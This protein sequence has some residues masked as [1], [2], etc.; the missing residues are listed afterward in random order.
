LTALGVPGFDDF[1]YQLIGRL[2]EASNVPI[3]AHC[4]NNFEEAGG[5]ALKLGVDGYVPRPFGEQE[6]AARIQALMRRAPE[7]FSNKEVYIDDALYI[8]FARQEVFLR[9]IEVALIPKE[10]KILA[11]LVKQ[12]GRTVSQ[13]ELR[14]KAWDGKDVPQNGVH[15]QIYRHRKKVRA[16]I[17]GAWAYHDHWGSRL[18]L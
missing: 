1:G 2:R 11:C 10:F 7:P 14:Q 18:S 13:G 12:A 15:W 17:R 5:P 8:D 9:D 6:L 16:G 4:I 3:L